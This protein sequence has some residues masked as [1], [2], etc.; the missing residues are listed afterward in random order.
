[1]SKDDW[2]D[3]YL[4]PK[5]STVFI[6]PWGLHQSHYE[7]PELYNP[8]RYLNHPRLA[9]DYAGSPDYENRDHYTYG[10]G[11][12]ICAGIH[13][14]ERIQWRLLA[15]LLWAFNIEPSID[16]TTGEAIELDTNAYTDGFII[17]P[18]PFQ[19]RFV[20]R[21]E[22]HVQVIRN[23]FKSVEGFLKQWE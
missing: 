19:V 3:N 5:D 13:L 4:I 9:M 16:E 22:K 21:S 6:P 8:D 15:R 17:Q 11:R 2:F 12:R 23:D 20:P 18:L 10:A 14:A 7:D 1:M